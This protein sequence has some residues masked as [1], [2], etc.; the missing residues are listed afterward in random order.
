MDALLIN[1]IRA[2]STRFLA[3]KSVSHTFRVLSGC[4]GIES[5]EKS[6]AGGDEPDTGTLALFRVFQPLI[7]S[8]LSESREDA[9][10]AA[11]T[12]HCALF[13][14]DWKSAS[15]IFTEDGFIDLLTT[16]ETSTSSPVSLALARLYAQASTR[17]SQTTDDGLRA[18]AI[19]AIVKLAHGSSS[20]AAALPVGTASTT[21]LLVGE[22]IACAAQLND[23]IMNSKDIGACLSEAVEGL[24]YLSTNLSVKKDLAN[25][26]FLKRLFSF[27]PKRKAAVDATN[28]STLI[29]GVLMIISNL[30]A[31]KPRLS[32]EQQQIAK[33]RRMAES[34]KQAGRQ[35]A[36]E[37]LDPLESEREVQARCRSAISC[38]ALDVLAT[39]SGLDS[40]GIRSSVGQ[41]LLSFAENKD[42]RGEILRGGGS[43]T[44]TRIF[45]SMSSSP[46]SLPQEA[47]PAIQALAKLA[48]TA[49]PFQVFGPNEGNVL[50]AIRPFSQLLLHPSASTLQQ[51]EGVMALTNLATHS[52]AVASRVA[53]IP[54][55][56]S[57]VELLMLE[58][59]TLMR[60]AATELICNLIAGS[61]QVFERYGANDEMVRSTSR[62]G[63]PKS[64]IHVLIA[65]SDV[66]DLP[67]RLAASGALAMLTTTQAACEA[68]FDLQKERHRAFLVLAQLIDP[69]VHAG[70]DDAMDEESNGGVGD[71][72][73]VHRVVQ[74]DLSFV[75]LPVRLRHRID[76]A[77]D[78]VATSGTQSKSGVPVGG[79][80]VEDPGP[81]QYEAGGFIIEELA[82]TQS[83][84]PLSEIPRALNLLDLSPDDDIMGVFKN[85]VTGWGAQN[86]CNNGVSRKDWR[87]VCAALLEGE[88]VDGSVEENPVVDEDM[89]T[90]SGPDSDEYQMDPELSDDSEEPLSDEYEEPSVSVRTKNI[91]Q[92][93]P[94]KRTK[95]ETSRQLTESQKAQC[96]REFSRFFP[97]VSDNELDHQRIMIKDI[98]RAAEL[99]KENL[100]TEEILEMLEAFSTSPDKSMNLADFEHMMI[101]TKLV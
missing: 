9:L 21:S 20:D 30:C 69:S 51:F 12:F 19:L 85:A 67:T 56:L 99:L 88:H 31:Y 28:N 63:S 59:H 2:L 13:Q 50:D 77:F 55:I 32:Q 41:I 82:S 86:A 39:A 3:L 66:E 62:D 17:S 47:L 23:M 10:L 37:Q 40:Q 34:G 52:P 60:R 61:E 46:D 18:V 101:L 4:S 80:I 6:Q 42:N 90:D 38:G 92:R 78:S 98:V 65:M 44:L 74:D 57:K 1:R 22:D 24:A 25:N 75:V 48:I 89:G 49:P 71:P 45:Q 81:S 93:T 11:V 33:L 27:V 5:S 36:E 87:A 68:I 64:K 79:F 97:Q 16:L 8:N 94:T 76:D 72:G 100:K 15:Q 43:K 73:L 26:T 54:H 70:D 96:R 53:N 91:P 58:D 7:A 29:Y 95:A 14:V 35:G 83:H 84:I